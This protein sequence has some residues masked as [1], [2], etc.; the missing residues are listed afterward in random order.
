MLPFN[1]N[2]LKNTYAKIKNSSKQTF[3]NTCKSV[4]NFVYEHSKE[5]AIIILFFNGISILSSHFA[6]INGL[7]KSNRE[8][9][10][11]LITQEKNELKLDLALTIIPPFII[12][13]LLTNKLDSGQWTT[14]SRERKL[15]EKIIG[16]TGTTANDY[17]NNL[18]KETIN[19]ISSEIKNINLPDYNKIKTETNLGKILDDFDKN[20]KYSSAQ[21]YNGS[22]YDD[23]IGSRNGMLLATTIFYSIV[24]SNIVMPILK[25]HLANKA[26]KKHLQE[27]GETEKSI[28]IQERFSF[29]ENPVTDINSE[30]FEKINS[31]CKTDK[32]EINLNTNILN[33]NLK[34]NNNFDLYSFNNTIYKPTYLRF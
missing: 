21:F 14:R 9:K 10:E 20:H 30:V 1:I 18:K 24:I 3:L 4:T 8:N 33:N 16:E 32:N 25:N 19:N 15:I 12:N 26:F 5:S 6:Q 28:K 27:T 31:L 11:Y 17:F 29:A 23:I 34:K 22:A 2:K 13:K 7:R